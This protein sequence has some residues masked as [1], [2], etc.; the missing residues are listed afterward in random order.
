MFK[1]PYGRL[2]PLVDYLGVPEDWGGQ[3]QGVNAV[4]NATMT[5]KEG[6]GI[7]DA[8]RAL[9]GGLGK[10][11]DLGGDVDGDGQHQPVPELLR[12][13]ELGGVE[14]GQVSGEPEEAAGDEQAAQRRCDCAFPGFVGTE[15]RGELMAAQGAAYEQ[16][17]NVSGP[18]DAEQE[19]DQ[20]GAVGLFAQ[21][22]QSQ[23]CEAGVDQ[24][25][26][27]DR[28]VGQHAL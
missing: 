19:S 27:G 6:A 25:E 13:R 5:G 18:D 8:N 12:K 14:L 21:G 3:Q 20:R 15:A 9:E 10:I 2:E 22:R 16:S 23:Q 7:F 28:G 11:A 17:S 24:G 4:E 26:D 1:N